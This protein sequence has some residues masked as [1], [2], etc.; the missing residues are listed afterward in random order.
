MTPNQQ[1]AHRSNPDHSIN[2][3]APY[4]ASSMTTRPSHQTPRSSRSDRSATAPRPVPVLAILTELTTL[5]RTLAKR[6]T[7]ILAHFD[8]PH[9][10][11]GPTEA[12]NGHLEHLRGTA[13]GFRNLANHIARSLLEPGGFRPQLHSRF[14]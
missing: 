5:G 9:T 2:A 8:R 14:G 3:L 10:P 13:L 11:N 1:H 4:I 7:G 12:N 6:A